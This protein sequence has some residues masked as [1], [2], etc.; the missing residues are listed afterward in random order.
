MKPRRHPSHRRLHRDADRLVWLARGL[1][2]SGSRVEDRYWE[3]ELASLIGSLLASGH[4]EAFNQ[5]LDR[6]QES[7]GRAYEELAD[8]VEAAVESDLRDAAEGP[9]Q[10]LLLALPV[11]AWSRYGIPAPTLPEQLLGNLRV[12]LKAHVLAADVRVGLADYLFSPDQLP[13]GHVEVRRL[14]ERLGDAALDDGN[15][16]IAVADLPESGRYVADP[17]YV[18]AAVA[19]AGNRPVFRWNE[20]DGSRQHAEDQWRAQA[21]PS[22]QAVLAGCGTRLLLPESFFSAWRRSDREAR[23]FSLATSVDFLRA[24]LEVHV[25]ELHAVIAA[26]YDHHLVEWRVGFGR[27]GEDAVLHGVVWPLFEEDEEG[28]EAVGEI[29]RILRE[30]G[31]NQIRV[32]EQRMP[33]EYCDDCGAPLYPNADGESVHAEMPEPA[34]DAPPAQLH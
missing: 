13:R 12:Q 30:A 32:L 5:A 14:T 1:A 31:L 29:E 10:V 19:V 33:L 4:D 18:L 21:G 24:T 27:A 25:G 22:L 23:A 3:G 8:L 28:S 34:G 16:E 15:L 17:R 26:Y 7:D 20:P 2:E 9:V 6:L 11:L